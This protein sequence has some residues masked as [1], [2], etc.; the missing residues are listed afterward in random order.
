MS[1]GPALGKSRRR[2]PESVPEVYRPEPERVVP[3]RRREA[4][5]LAAIAGGELMS[6]VRLG[7]KLVEE[8]PPKAI[9]MH[10]PRE[11][12]LVRRAAAGIDLKRLDAAKADLAR[13]L[14]VVAAAPPAETEEAPHTDELEIMATQALVEDEMPESQR[15]HGID[16]RVLKEFFTAGTTGS[17]HTGAA[18][19]QQFY[20]GGNRP[21]AGAMAVHR[22]SKTTPYGRRLR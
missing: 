21:Y 16:R 8:D 11:T 4:T 12:D 6:T 9:K 20:S 5:T 17:S 7:N 13:T 2:M 3:R 15:P 22:P 10:A 19:A 14:E 1:T 18:A